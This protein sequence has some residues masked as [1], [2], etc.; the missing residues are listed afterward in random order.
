[1]D[2]HRLF[3]IK[4]PIIRVENDFQLSLYNDQKH[5]QGTALGFI[6]PSEPDLISS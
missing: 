6:I 5:V 4:T 1:M 3:V 2:N